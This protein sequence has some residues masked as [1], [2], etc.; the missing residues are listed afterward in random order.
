VTCPHLPSNI[1]YD[2]KTGDFPLELLS[3]SANVCESGCFRPYQDARAHLT[4]E[5]VG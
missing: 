4:S 5:F 2:T 1:V 3:Y